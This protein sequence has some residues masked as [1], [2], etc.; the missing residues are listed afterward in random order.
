MTARE[1]FK[2]VVQYIKCDLTEMRET[3]VVAFGHAN[4][5]AFKYSITV[6]TSYYSHYWYMY[7]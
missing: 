5:L 4:E 6:T 7:Y 2:T 3:T 1:L